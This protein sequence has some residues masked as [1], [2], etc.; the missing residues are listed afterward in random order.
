[1]GPQLGSFVVN[2][3]SI[4][5]GHVDITLYSEQNGQGSVL[6]TYGLNVTGIPNG[7]GPT[8][9]GWFEESDALANAL[10]TGNIQYQSPP[11]NVLFSIVSST[12]SWLA[13][14]SA[15]NG[16][17][18]SPGYF[19]VG[20]NCVDGLSEVLAKLFVNENVSNYMKP[21]SLAVYAYA[22]AISTKMTI[23]TPIGGVQVQANPLQFYWNTGGQV[24]SLIGQVIGQ[25]LVMVGATPPPAGETEP[26]VTAAQITVTV[27]SS[28]HTAT[29]TY[30]N[31]NDPYMY[32]QN[33]NLIG[34][35]TDIGLSSDIINALIADLQSLTSSIDSFFDLPFEY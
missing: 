12:N 20:N 6:G 11:Q 13:S 30:A 22:L 31:P 32:D 1:M 14:Q 8:D 28:S 10:S 17:L 15:S 5:T 3:Y 16:Q 23:P 7:S 25:G 24:A 2:T 19:V 35:G 4:G 33:G 18:G 27:S 21:S 26:T 34:S 29:I 9:G